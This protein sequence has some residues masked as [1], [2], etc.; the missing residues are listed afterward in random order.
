MALTTKKYKKKPIKID[1]VE[2]TQANAEDVAKWAH[3]KVENASDPMTLSVSIPTLEGVMTASIG[4]FVIQGVEGEV[5][6]CK[7][8]IFNATYEEVITV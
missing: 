4:D 6:P 7:P 1:A 3:G 8:S 2:L 5:Y